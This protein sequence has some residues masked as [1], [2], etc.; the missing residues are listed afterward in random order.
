LAVSKRLRFEILRRDNHTCRY[1]GGAAPEVRLRVDHVVP[2]ALGGQTVPENLVAAC[3]PCNAGKSSIAPDSAVVADVSED[4]IR[5]TRAMA[6]ARAIRRAFAEKRLAYGDYFLELWE[7]WR[8]VETQELV[9]LDG[10][11]RSTVDKFFEYDVDQED[12]RYAVRAA[13][14]A[15]GV[16]P[17]NTFRYFCGVVWNIIRDTEAMA[18]QIITAGDA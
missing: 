3:E 16:R 2:E 15:R 17:E 9:P 5:W 4:Q 7:G 10:D 12:I 11:W 1:C 6:E 13:M 8:F 18:R 14:G